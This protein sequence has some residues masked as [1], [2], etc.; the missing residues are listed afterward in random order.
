[1]KVVHLSTIDTGGAGIAAMR[2][3][4][5]LINAGVE[6]NMLVRTKHSDDNTVTQAEPNLDLYVPPRNPLLR[7]I[8]KVLRRR[9]HHLTQV[10]QYERAMGKLDNLYVAS[11]TSP[12]S[13][14]DLST[15]PLVQEADIIHL[16]WIENFVDYQT[17]F[18][19][20][21]KP[22][23]WTIHDENIAYGGFH[24]RDE[25]IEL[26]EPFAEIENLFVKTKKEALGK[27]QNIHM[28]ALSEQMKEFYHA[29]AIQPE[30]PA[31]IIYNGITPED[32]QI[33]DHDYCRKI[34]GISNDRIVLCF[35][36]SD[37]NDKHKGLSVL[38]RALEQ[39]ND[40]TITLLCVGKGNLP[41][42]KV[43]IIGTG[44]IPNPRLLSIAYSASDLFTM[45]SLQESFAQAPIEAMACGC[46]VV[47]FPCG[48]IPELITKE[49]G[50]CC[51]GFTME[52]LIT[53]IKAALGTKYDR[54]VISKDAI[55]RFNISKIAGQYLD[56]YRSICK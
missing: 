39:L 7:K 6:S 30:Y 53:G 16:H 4:H 23:V 42:S 1:M 37:M 20:V 56:L 35:C 44:P 38:V 17:F 15:H 40:P 45:P 10:E 54:E 43:D 33:L 8:D 25:A 50:I 14:Y 52:A 18:E 46:S 22:I 41:K 3:H 48:I 9:G 26:K 32:F 49:N 24:Y 13:N 27:E 2:I 34:L 29:H 12:L 11:Y 28:V 36:A 19:R 21:N 47:A 55:E 51:Q 31:S 5:A